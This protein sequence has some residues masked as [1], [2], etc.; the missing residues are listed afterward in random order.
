MQ[1][2]IQITCTES[3]LLMIIPLL[4]TYVSPRLGGHTAYLV[5]VTLYALS[6]AEKWLSHSTA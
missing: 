4:A 5:G 2:A 6:H 3:L 1:A